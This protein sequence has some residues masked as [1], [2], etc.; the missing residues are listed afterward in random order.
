VLTRLRDA[1]R[2]A[3]RLMAFSP[4]WVC[5]GL[6]EVEFDALGDMIR[7]FARCQH[8]MAPPPAPVGGGHE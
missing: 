7:A 6:V 4:D 2:S 8:C 3:R 1:R 5:R